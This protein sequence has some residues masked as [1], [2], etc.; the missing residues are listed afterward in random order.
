MAKK[1]YAYRTRYL[2]A[3]PRNKRLTEGIQQAAQSGGGGGTYISSGGPQY[4]Q[5]V[6]TDADGNP[7]EETQ[8]Y[9]QP[10]QGKHLLIPGD[11]VAYATDPDLEDIPFPVA[12]YSQ[13]GILS[14]QSGTGLILENGVLRLDPD[15]AG[16]GGGIDTEQ[17]EQYLTQKHYV[18]QTW[19]TENGY[20]KL[21]SPLTGYTKPDAYAPLTDEDTLIG[22][23]GKLEANFGNYVDLTTDQTI[24]GDKTFNNLIIGK[25]DIVCYATGDVEDVPFPIASATQLGVI[26]VGANL[27]IS[28]DGTLSA[29]AGSS[30]VQFTPGT[31]LELTSSSVLNVLIGT[32]SGT[33][34]AGNDSRLTTAYSQS[35][36]H[37]NKSVLD[38]ITSTY[39]SNWNTAYNLSHSHSNKFVLDG[40]TS[41]LVSQWNN[42]YNNAHWHSNKSYLDTINQD[43]ANTDSPRFGGL[44]LR[45]SGPVLSFYNNSDTGLY[46]RIVYPSTSNLELHRQSTRVMS[47]TGSGDLIA[48]GD[49]VAYSNSSSVSDISA[50][51]TTTTYG[52]VKY[53]GS[54]IG[55]NSNGQL[56]VIGGTGGGSTDPVYWSD[57]QGKP[58]VLSTVQ[59]TGSGNVVTAVSYSGSSITVTKENV[60]GGG[61]DVSWSSTTNNTATL[62]VDGVAKQLP[63]SSG[64]SVNEYSSYA[65]IKIVGYSIN[66][67]LNNHTHS[68][69]SITGKPSILSSITYSTSGSGNVVTNVTASGST[70]YVTKGNVSGGSSWNGGTVTNNI[71][72]SRSGATLL[73]QNGSYRWAFQNSGSTLYLMKNG[74]AHL[75]V[76]GANWTVNSDERIKDIGEPVGLILDQL[77]NLRV[78]HFTYKNRLELGKQVGVIAQDVRRVLPEAVSRGAYDPSV[79][80]YVLGVDYS[81][82]GAVIAIAGLKEL[83]ARFRPVENKVKVLEQQVRNLQLRLDNAYKEIFTL[84]EGKETA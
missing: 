22:A 58:N 73:L 64:F 20:L 50:V 40:I 81:T 70:V 68:W 37:S 80:D 84:K 31:A 33:V 77:S 10:V 74:S 9:L 35:H 65:A 83:Y 62:N 7:L 28:A 29:V 12:S 5:L 23:I 41:T 45:S 8:Y 13:Q 24:G 76:M 27:T 79:G 47:F 1:Q 46:W 59:T 18:T 60:S 75:Y 78:V 66:V 56:Y 17:L 39:V 14:V 63:L 71:T 25:D 30:G 48:V 82:L 16:G 52:L 32:T 26:K 4:W 11:V 6:T 54:T 34:C 53:D 55:K 44:M 19:L 42:A 38:G 49:V 3:T 61:S 51:A 72:I 43:M 57:I 67:S 36:T 69:S 2:A 21:T 15:Y